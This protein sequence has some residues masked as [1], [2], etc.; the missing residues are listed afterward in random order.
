MVGI[1]V[2]TRTDMFILKESSAQWMKLVFSQILVKPQK[3]LF[4]TYS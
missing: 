4:F 3:R 2:T 1:T